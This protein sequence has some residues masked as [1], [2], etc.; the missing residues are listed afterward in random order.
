MSELNNPSMPIID[1]ERHQKIETAT[2]SLG[3]FWGPDSEFGAMEGVIRTRVGY[4]GGSYE[5]PTY[6]DIGD[7]IETLQIDYDP[8]IIPYKELAEI[9]WANH[10]PFEP[11]WNRQYAKAIFY[12]NPDQL[13]TIQ[14]IKNKI[15]GGSGRS[16][17]TEINQYQ[18]FYNAENYHQKYHL[19]NIPL[20]KRDYKNI[21]GSIEDFLNSTSAARVNGYVRGYGR[22]EDFD[23][24]L[25]R[26]GLSEESLIELKNIFYR[27]KKKV[28]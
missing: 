10:D 26:L 14:L 3:C 9:F 21:F 1:S 11:P 24:N 18:R 16:V 22:V 8:D 19:Q 7:H 2:F 15:K 23:N 4:S 25:R 20:L 13:N 5:N 28:V 17:N 12:H 27:F 6:H